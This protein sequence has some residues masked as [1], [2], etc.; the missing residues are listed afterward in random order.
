M[1]IF[2]LIVLTGIGF[3]TACSTEGTKNNSK[4]NEQVSIGPVLSKAE[5]AIEPKDKVLDK[6]EFQNGMKIQWFE[7]GS[8]EKLK[9]EEVYEINFKIKTNKGQVIDGNHLLKKDWI[10]FL[11]GMN[12]Y[13][14]GM[15][16]AM[17]ELAVGDFVEVFLPANL[18]RGNKEIKGLVAGNTSNIIFIKVGK[19]IKP[20]KV[21]DGVKVWLFE[22][23]KEI[24]DAKITENSNVAINYFVGTKT[25]PRY[26][27]SYERGAPFTFGMQD[28]S[29][30]PGLKK[31]MLGRKMFDKVWVLVPAKQA[32]G[33][34]GMTD[35]VKPNESI[36]Y[37]LF[38][39]DV[40]KKSV[41]YLSEEDKLSSK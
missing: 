32:Y 25:N 26:D 27:N 1:K 37:D 33:A 28:F 31:A 39:V 36:F 18:A 5:Q 10:P 8:G 12:T 20:T 11:V 17:N 15:E 41:N 9:A 29:L 23:N 16:L 6:K 35:L 13:L 14:P 24:K 38:I 4:K 21:I 30:I 34:K 22:E 2:S 40:D 19:R 7:K 3:L